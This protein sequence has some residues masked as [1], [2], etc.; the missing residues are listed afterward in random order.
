MY[1]DKKKIVQAIEIIEGTLK[2]ADLP[3]DVIISRQVKL[4][5]IFNISLE[6]QFENSRELEYELINPN[7]D[8]YLN[9]IHHHALNNSIFDFY[10]ILK[11][12]KDDVTICDIGSASSLLSITAN[13]FFPNIKVISIEPVAKRMQAAIA[14]NKELMGAHEFYGTLFDSRYSN[15]N[16]DYALLYFPT[17]RAL[18]EILEILTRR[19]DTCIIAI[20]SHGDLLFRL[21]QCGKLEKEQQLVKMVSPRHNPF[22]HIYKINPEASPTESDTFLREFYLENNFA[23]EIKDS[24]GT[25]IGLIESTDIYFQHDKNNLITMKYPP[26]SISTRGEIKFLHKEDLDDE[27]LKIINNIKCDGSLIRKVYP[28]LKLVELADGEKVSFDE[29]SKYLIS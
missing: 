7:G 20:E 15:L 21:D 25:W 13:L 10:K 3:D 6:I 8:L 5:S 9:D 12:L 19:K 28:K 16:F 18:E 17:G 14:L 4:L 26:R 2:E 11:K 1:K 23:M 24:R 22:A 29:L 27:T